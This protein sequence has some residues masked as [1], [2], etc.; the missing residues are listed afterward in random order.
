[1]LKFKTNKKFIKL[2]VFIIKIITNFQC[3]I[4]LIENLSVYLPKIRLVY[5]NVRRTTVVRP[6][7]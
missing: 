7:L 5:S 3:R 4:M 2:S 1:M 6:Q